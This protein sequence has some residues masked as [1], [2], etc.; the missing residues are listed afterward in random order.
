MTIGTSTRSG[1][2]IAT[3][4]IAIITNGRGYYRNGLWIQF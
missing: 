4:T 1:T 2:T 3:I